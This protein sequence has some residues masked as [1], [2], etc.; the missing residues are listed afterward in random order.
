MRLAIV[1]ATLLVTSN[2]SAAYAHRWTW[3]SAPEPAALEKCVTE[4]KGLAARRAGEL[5][6][7][8]TGPRE[9]RLNGR[10]DLAQEEFVFPGAVGFNA[11]RTE[12][13]PYDAVVTA[14][15]I[16]AR[17]CFSNEVLEIKSDGDWVDWREGRLLWE[18]V[19]GT[20]AANPGIE[21]RHG[22]GG[23]LPPAIATTHE[24]FRKPW[25]IVIALCVLGLLLLMIVPTKK[26]SA[27]DE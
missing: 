1:C 26:S 11:V 18:E 9:I 22:P 16:A 14:S 12:G 20:M 5:E 3:K 4:M 15:L 2:A 19:H 23:K 27:S 7:P 6:I 21:E 24:Q 8:Q 13:K 25:A 17:S 10:S